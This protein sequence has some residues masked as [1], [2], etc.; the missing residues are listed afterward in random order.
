MSEPASLRR[1]GLLTAKVTVVNPTKVK[2]IAE[3]RRQ[4]DKIDAKIL[5]E[6]LR[7][8]DHLLKRLPA[9]TTPVQVVQAVEDDM[10]SP[11]NAHCIYRRIRSSVKEIVLLKNS[12]HVITV[13]QERDLV[14]R[15]M[16]EFFQR[17]HAARLANGRTA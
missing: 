11:K 3:S 17:A 1:L 8:V 7:L 6:L 2:L 4:T 13:D 9:I 10:T 14:A 16:G 5:C 12:Y 15:K